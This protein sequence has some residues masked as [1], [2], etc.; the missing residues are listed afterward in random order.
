MEKTIDG[1]IRAATAIPLYD[2]AYKLWASRRE[3]SRLEVPTTI[4]K[5]R[6]DESVDWNTIQKVVRGVMAA[7]THERAHAAN[8]PIFEILRAAHPE[9]SD[10]TLGAAIQAAADFEL[11]CVRHF[12]Y[13]SAHLTQDANHAIE[14][15]RAEFPQFQEETYRLASF[16]LVKAMR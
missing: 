8:G 6:T 13:A 4:P 3:Y 10:V 14:A 1:V 11:A 5:P 9:A 2:A 7:A 16:R 15:A 12:K